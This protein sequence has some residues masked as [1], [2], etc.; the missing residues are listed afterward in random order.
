MTIALADIAPAAERQLYRTP[1]TPS[2]GNAF[3][4]ERGLS[5]TEKTLRCSAAVLSSCSR[6][7]K[8]V[9]WSAA[10]RRALVDGA[11]LTLSCQHAAARRPGS[12]SWRSLP[13]ARPR[14]GRYPARAI[15]TA[16]QVLWRRWRAF[17]ARPPPSRALTMQA[18]HAPSAK[19]TAAW[20]IEDIRLRRDRAKCLLIE[21]CG[22]SE[23]EAHTAATEQQAMNN[24]R[25][26][27]DIAQGHHMDLRH[28]KLSQT[29]FCRCCALTAVPRRQN[30]KSSYA[31]TFGSE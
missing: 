11:N 2:R 13:Q 16:S 17:V 25:L 4:M 7:C 24:R 12:T 9:R 5:S 26:K 19:R 22:M 31:E 27:R 8:A 23:P 18:P 20:R 29:A 21:R 30:T 3:H 14:A 28:L 15:R 1:P 6:S 10:K